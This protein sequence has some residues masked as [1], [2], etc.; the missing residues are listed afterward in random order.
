MELLS[1]PTPSP[2]VPQSF[3]D[4]MCPTIAAYWP[5]ATPTADR[6]PLWILFSC[7]ALTFTLC[8]VTL[9]MDMRL[10][11]GYKSRKGFL[12]TASLTFLW[13][14]ALMLIPFKWLRFPLVFYCMEMPIYWSFLCVTFLAAAVVRFLLSV[15]PT[16]GPARGRTVILFQVLMALVVLLIII[17]ASV[18]FAVYFIHVDRLPQLDVGSV[19]PPANMTPIQPDHY[20][21]LIQF[22]LFFLLCAFIGLFLFRITRAWGHLLSDQKTRSRL[23]AFLVLV[24]VF[25][26]VFAFRSVWDLFYF[27]GINPLQDWINSLANDHHMSG[28]WAVSWLWQTLVEIAPLTGMAVVQF[29]SVLEQQRRAGFVRLPNAPPGV[30]APMNGSRGSGLFSSAYAPSGLVATATGMTAAAGT[31]PGRGSGS[32]A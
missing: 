9:I 20:T 1:T 32:L 4:T 29:V 7:Y 14:A 25:L 11:L 28:Y 3:V 18:I 15:T 23:Q 22:V 31:A 8:V 27:A 2:L 10:K 21:S 13:R 17:G 24:W 6:W 12:V 26:G 5:D 30:P 16:G 19:T